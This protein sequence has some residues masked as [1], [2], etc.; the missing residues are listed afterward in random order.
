MTQNYLLPGFISFDLISNSEL[1]IRQRRDSTTA[2]LVEGACGEVADAM[3][4][5]IALRKLAQR[6]VVVAP[7]PVEV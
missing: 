4:R 1:K 3:A 2:D 7:F 5:K 6:R